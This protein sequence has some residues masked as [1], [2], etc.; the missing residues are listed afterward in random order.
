MSD[1]VRNPQWRESIAAWDNALRD[2]A[3]TADSAAE[4]GPGSAAST[5]EAP[6]AL[7]DGDA[8]ETV[9]WSSEPTT[10]ADLNTKYQTQFQAATDCGKGSLLLTGCGK[11]FICSGEAPFQHDKMKTIA[12]IGQGDWIKPPKSVEQQNDS[13]AFPF[14][15]NRDLVNV[16]LETK[17]EGRTTMRDT[18]RC[19]LRTLLTD[20]ETEGLV[21][22]KL[23]G[24]TISRP[25][26]AAASDEMDYFNVTNIADSLWVWK[27]RSPKAN[28]AKSQNTICS[29]LPAQAL[30]SSPMLDIAWRVNFDMTS[31][32]VIPKK[33]LVFLKED[34]SLP[35]GHCRR[36]A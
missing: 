36:L 31:S 15:V 21:D 9:D 35:P 17:V 8:A 29:W 28:T 13:N 1:P 19:T 27:A 12:G 32:T 5:S 34:L 7:Q 10:A 2:R 22:T 16:V 25:D 6:L 4:S 33:V 18:E 24:H 23:H 26:G 30:R 20:M 11:L 3:V 14:I